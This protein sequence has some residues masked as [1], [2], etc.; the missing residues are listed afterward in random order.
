M[1][2]ILATILPSIL[3]GTV[4]IVIGRSNKRNERKEEL[5]KQESI[6]ILGNIDAIG[7]LSYQTARCHKG[8]CP[9]GD[10]TEAMEYQK[11]QKINLQKYLREVS[12]ENR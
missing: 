3:S 9:N 2:I 1:E 4:L 6:L 12:A 11:Q 5:R 8:E 7:T 10:L